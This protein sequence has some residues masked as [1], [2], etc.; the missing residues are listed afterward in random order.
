MSALFS[1]FCWHSALLIT[2]CRGF[3]SSAFN[4]SGTTQR[5]AW[6]SIVLGAVYISLLIDGLLYKTD[7]FSIALCPLGLIDAMQ[8][9][10]N[11]TLVP[12]TDTLFHWK[13]SLCIV[14]CLFCMIL[15]CCIPT[16]GCTTGACTA[17]IRHSDTFSL[18]DKMVPGWWGSQLSRTG[19]SPNWSDSAGFYCMSQEWPFR[20]FW[21]PCVPI[22]N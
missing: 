2:S 16:N 7:C 19:F 13:I 10:V 6:R 21:T 18:E 5:P 9:S 1:L 12:T 8:L 17:Y 3:V 15:R 22:A 20:L 4:N 14:N 11:S